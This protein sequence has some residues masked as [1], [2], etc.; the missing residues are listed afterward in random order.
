MDK[1]K[2][3]QEDMEKISTL[4]TKNS[5]FFSHNDPEIVKWIGTRKLDI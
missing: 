3:I 5:V 4:D 1:F 2:L